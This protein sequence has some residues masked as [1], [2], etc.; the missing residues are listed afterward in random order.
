MILKTNKGFTLVEVLVAAFILVVGILGALLFFASA[1]TST[2]SA[3]DI[4]AATSHGEYVLEEMKTRTSLANIV[5]TS[6]SA[7]ATGENLCTLPAES[8]TVAITNSQANPLDIRL[9]VNWTRK[10]RANTVTLRTQITK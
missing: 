8:V 10:A 4:T 5:N 1:M 9:D 6:W 2:E 3:G 7:W